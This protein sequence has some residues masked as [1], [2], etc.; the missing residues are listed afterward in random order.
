M[1]RIRYALQVLKDDRG[2]GVVEVILILVVLIGLVIIFKS[3]LTSLVQ[4]IF[5][6]ITSESSVIYVIMHSKEAAGCRLCRYRRVQE[7]RPDRDCLNGEVT[8]YLT[9]TFVL[10]VS[11]ILALVESASVQMAK[12]YRRA[13]MNRALECVFAEYQKE[14]LENYD[15][16][17]IECGY[18]TG[19][20]TEQN[21]LDRLSYYG[22]DM[23]NEIERI[24][25]FTDNSGELF[26]DQVGKY[27][28]HK[29]GIAWADKYLGNVS[30]WKNQEEKADE[31]TEEEEKQNDQLKDL[32]GEQEA[33]LPEEENPMQ[34]V[35]ELK[36]S[37]ILELV[38]P[39]DKTI[40]EKQISLQEMP[41]K[42]ENHTG[43]GA[44]SDV[45]PEEGTLTSVLLG[46]YVIDHFT[47]FTD[48]PKGGELDYELEYIL[49]G[50]ESDKRNLETVA[51]K[52]VMLR[53]VPNYIYLQTSSTKQAEAR[54]AAGTLCTL[55]AVPAVT[56][57][58]AQGILLAWA[59][60]ESVM[61]VRSLLDGQKAAITKDDTNWQLSLS[62]LMKL[63]TDE[64]TGTGMDVQDG[65]GY[66]DYMR[67][68][69]FLEGKERMSMRAM[70]I[71]EKNMQ[72]I[73]GQPAFRIDYCAGRMEIRTVCNLRRGIKYQYRT[74]YG[75]Q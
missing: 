15:V 75:Y 27:M 73:Y 25:L 49:A 7:K 67:M 41:E 34:H 4:T 50:R 12:N 59:Y 46:E 55:L 60:G 56:E 26:R 47:D 68:L 48:E 57:A 38:L 74:Y 65:M 22:A 18:E 1:W 45:E 10:F 2:I 24:Q 9:L 28:K 70:G 29:Y 63:G 51:K 39:K 35:A 44:F 61:D 8:V 43:Y 62:G 42:R 52:L 58:A 71:I 21:I 23:E 3:Q 31:F 11:L 19:T 66:K 54:A 64:D 6:K 69:L 37:P 30:L 14:L 72:S 5:E 53:F 33:E 40:S 32:L 36:R 17:A 20:Y 13:D 16:F